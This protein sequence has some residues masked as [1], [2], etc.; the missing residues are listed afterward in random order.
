MELG[1]LLAVVQR[2]DSTLTLVGNEAGEYHHYAVVSVEV[3]EHV[4]NE[5]VNE[6]QAGTL[7]RM[8]AVVQVHG[9]GADGADYGVAA[10]AIHAAGAGENAWA[11]VS[12]ALV[13]A[14]VQRSDGVGVKSD[15]ESESSEEEQ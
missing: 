3:V 13:R 11:L 8:E 2:Q 9:E 5:L 4:G 6:T 12:S 14:D 7:G 10:V 1:W 15:V